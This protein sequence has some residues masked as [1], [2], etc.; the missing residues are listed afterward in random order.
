MVH[1]LE[2]LQRLEAKFDSLS[3]SYTSTPSSVPTSTSTAQDEITSGLT[4]AA[5][6][7]R[8]NHNDD[9]PASSA[10]PGELQ[11]SY[12]HLTAAHK[13]ILW[14]AVYLCIFGAEASAADDLQYVMQD[15]TLWLLR[16]EFKKQ[17]AFT[18]SP[19]IHRLLSSNNR[20]HDSRP[21]FAGL[22]IDQIQRL[23][24]A[25]F[26]TFNII[27]PILS[28][29]A[30]VTDT[31]G[32]MIR[33]GYTENDASACLALLVFALGQVAIDGVFGPPIS[34]INGVQSGIRGGS[35]VDPPGLELFNEAR[36]LIGF[37][38]HQCSLE[39]VQIHLLQ[40]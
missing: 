34:S 9:P 22:E 33:N 4:P 18:C 40:A 39:N 31:V 14:P 6:C 7:A 3:V 24:D 25:Y 29:E 8:S 11:R 10:S 36:R 15:G 28:R 20:F 19:H 32:P 27:S 35:A 1:I 13:V 23:T 12:R 38:M 21:V 30:F 26:N 2:T 17:Q 16:L 5:E 37:I